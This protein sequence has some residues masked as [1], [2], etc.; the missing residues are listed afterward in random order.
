MRVHPV[1]H[2]SLL[3]RH[4]HS[5]QE[6]VARI[7]APPPPVKISGQDDEYEVDSILDKR[8]HYRKTQYL[9]KWKGYPSYDAT[10]EPLEYLV[11]A[12]DAI[13]EYEA[14]R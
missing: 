8:T 14:L 7:Q 13:T 9:V 5:P 3:K 10:W 1:F 4:R 2:I 11:H 6:F 12:Q